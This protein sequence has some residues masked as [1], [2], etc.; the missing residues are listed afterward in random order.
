M[1]TTNASNWCRLAC[2]THVPSSVTPTDTPF[3]EMRQLANFGP[4]FI[5]RIIHLLLQTGEGLKNDQFDAAYDLSSA[6]DGTSTGY[7]N[8]ASLLSV[9]CL[10]ILFRRVPMP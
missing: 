2:L 1:T 4:V 7:H 10:V 3:R 5:P 6:E 8:F 9:I